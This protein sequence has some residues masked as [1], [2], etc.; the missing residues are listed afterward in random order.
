MKSLGAQRR[1]SPAHP[2][3]RHPPIMAGDTPQRE[4]SSLDRFHAVL[5]DPSDIEQ[6]ILRA[7][8]RLTVMPDQTNGMIVGSVYVSGVV[9]HLACTGSTSQA[10][11]AKPRRLVA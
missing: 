8:V 1:Q 10:P 4:A 3:S 5:L 7:Y 9:S 2:D 11:L 6:E